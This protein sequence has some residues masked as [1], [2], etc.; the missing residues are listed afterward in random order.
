[1]WSERSTAGLGASCALC[2]CP[3]AA[4]RVRR[5]Q[6]LRECR[7]SRAQLAA[8]GARRMERLLAG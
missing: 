5:R 8:V 1:M 3:T 4:G 6:R 2:V 7:H